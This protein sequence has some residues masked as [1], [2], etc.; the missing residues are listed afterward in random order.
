[1][2]IPTHLSME[3]HLYI[4]YIFNFLNPQGVLVTN[5]YLREIYVKIQSNAEFI[6]QLVHLYIMNNI[7]TCIVQRLV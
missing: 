4:P 7:K 6:S 5:I 2:D 1:M 3:I